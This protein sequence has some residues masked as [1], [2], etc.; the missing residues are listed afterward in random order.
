MV[1]LCLWWWFVWVCSFSMYLLCN[2]CWCR[3]LF[4]VRLGGGSGLSFN[5]DIWLCW[6]M[7]CHC[8]CIKW[9]EFVELCRVIGCS[10]DE[11]WCVLRLVNYV[12]LFWL[13]CW[14]WLLVFL[15]VV[16][17]V[18]LLS[19]FVHCSFVDVIGCLKT[20]YG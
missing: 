5:W 13:S 7:L 9:F 20:N 19:A 10:G 1:C 6:F 3:L 8:L 11:E 14:L 18:I 15:L 12:G 17:I 2:V 4:D 16:F